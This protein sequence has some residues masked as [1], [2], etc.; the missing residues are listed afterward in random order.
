MKKALVVLLSASL[1]LGLAA[2]SNTSGSSEGTTKAPGTT[3]APTTPAPTEPETEPVESDDPEENLTIGRWEHSYEA[4]G[5]GTR[6]NYFHFYKEVPVLGKVFY[7]SFSN[8]GMNFAGTYTVAKESTEWAAYPDR[9]TKIDDKS[10]DDSGK[11]KGTADYTVTFFDWNGKELGKLPYDGKILYNTFAD[12]DPMAAQGATEVF[13]LHDG[14][15]EK[16]FYDGELGQPF[17]SYV[18]DEDKTSTL[19]INHDGTYTDLVF[20]MVEGTYV[21][22]DGKDG[23]L[24]ITLTPNDKTD[25]G[26]VVTTSA[27]RKT[28]VYK[29]DGGDEIAMHD[30][31]DDAAEPSDEPAVE[32]YSTKTTANLGVDVEFTLSFMDDGTATMSANAMGTEM[33]ITADYEVDSAHIIQFTNVSNGAFASKLAAQYK[34]TWT[35]DLSERAKG[36]EV[37]FEFPAQ[38]L[39]KI[40]VDPAKK[41]AREQTVEEKYSTKATVNLGID[42]EFT[43]TFYSDKTAVMSANAMGTEMKITADWEVDAAH[44]IQFTNVSKGAFASKLASPYKVTWTGDLSEKATGKEIVFEFPPEDLAKL[45]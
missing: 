43:L 37:V 20:A 39:G 19:Q 14:A 16:T 10:D 1:V 24:E 6:F 25:T 11:S 5:Y 17:L 29:Q 26:A 2:C 12:G 13:Y 3:A 23:G 35:G 41:A 44:I 7:A 33:K 34:V 21:I 27:D 4:E 22:A 42:V 38:D 15:M 40:V 31:N 45:N 18:G 9:Q 28:C 8:N 32:V 36:I 30:V